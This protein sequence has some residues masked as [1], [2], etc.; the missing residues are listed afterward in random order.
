MKEVIRQLASYD[1]LQGIVEG[2]PIRIFWKDRDCN[3]L[4]C[5]TL[6][7]TDAGL[8][9]PDELIGKTDFD[10]GWKDQAE[11]YRA[12]DFSVM[13]SGKSR[14]RFEEPQTTPDGETA[15]LRTS[16]VPLRDKDKNIIGILGIYEDITEQKQVEQELKLAKAV[17][18]QAPLNITL[19]DSDARIHYINKTGCE[20]LGYTEEELLKMS[21]PDIDPLFPMEVWEQHW[22]E[23][24][25]NKS[26]PV[27]TEHRRKNGDIFPIEVMANYIEFGDQ[28]YNVAF[29]TDI[30]ERKQAEE[31]LKQSEAR[32]RDLFESSP[33][34]C[35]IID[36]NNL[37][38]LCNQAAADILGYESI[39][40]LQSTHPSK[41][42]PEIQPDGQKSFEKANEMMASAH[43][44]GV[45]RFEWIHLR[46]NGDC[47][48]V[49]VTLARIELAGKQQ[50]YC[51]WRDITE[52]K[53]VEEKLLSSEKR[54]D[55][56]MQGANDG[57][58]DWDL[59]TDEVYY[60]P[61]WF[62]MLGYDADA[63]PPVIDTWGELV[64][65]D[66]KDWILQR[67]TDYLEGRAGSFE[68][69]MRMCHK[70]G[71][72]VIVLSRASKV[73]R[74]SD[75]KP[76]RLVGTHVDITERKRVETKLLES[77]KRHREAQ[78]ISHLGNWSHNLLTNELEWSDEIFRIFG[79]DK[80]RFGASYEAFLDT[81]HPDDR[82]L[83]N[84]AYNDSVENRTRYSIEHRLLMKD[85]SIKWV[86]EHCA[87]TYAADGTPLI[88]SGTVLDITERKQQQ[89][90][91]EAS[92]KKF[93]T[94]FESSSDGLFILDMQGSFL[95]INRTAHE[96]LGYSKE[97]MLKM[98]L[99][100]LDPPEF[101]ARV[102]E[103]I[104]QILERGMATFESAHYRKDGSIMPVEINAR[105]I[106]LDGEKVLFSVIRDISDR[107][108][109]EDQ[110]RHSQKMEAIGTLVGGIAHDFN[111]MLAAMQG[112]IYMAKKQ[113]QDHPVTTDRLANIEQLSKRAADM[114]QQLLT[115]A[116]KDIV[117]M[118]LFSLN[119]FMEEGYKLIHAT[120]PENIDHQNIVC[121]ENLCIYGDTTQL[122]QAMMNLINNAVDAVADVPHPV[123]R[124]ILTPFESDEAFRQRHP[125]LLK[126]RFAC[127]TVK[128]NG[129][130]IPDEQLDKIFEPFFTTKDVGKGSG[131][132]LAML[133]GAIQT[134]GG[135][136]E[137]E[138]EA[139]SGTSF[140]VYFPLSDH[141]IETEIEEQMPGTEV[142]GETILLVDDE[143]D[144]RTTTSEVLTSMGYH[145]LEAVDGAEALD[146]FKSEMGRINII[147]T[148]VVMPRMSGTDLLN[149]VRLLDRKLPVILATG[150]DK[151]HLQGENI[152]DKSCRLINKPFDFDDLSR[153]IQLMLK[154][155]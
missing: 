111:N 106:E 122:Q 13:K 77:R 74:D 40:A 44:K 48:P 147:I 53:Q 140:R 72:D 14:L 80:S 149:S 17:M 142:H 105:I 33:D 88:S 133:Y 135:V 129:H 18:D 67:V 144:V 29:D 35:W 69:E 98:K 64:H 23:L 25:S 19:L 45:H 78:R 91:L 97:E 118:S 141:K 81:I 43:E 109:L 146:L 10:M 154:P 89:M 112:N 86:D 34:P 152:Q 76:V 125:A 54:F 136:I 134:H 21:I 108:M 30:T 128:D 38:T 57:L 20:T 49:E 71:H 119:A 15:W 116:R 8:S 36:E 28:A 82:E 41:L 6:F 126:E 117:E 85:G 26:V 92:R 150:Y 131:L 120:I 62:D 137:V 51:V 83:V 70:D 107:K 56:A 1:L 95:D 93:S 7:A 27:E 55:L 103:R 124:C 84:T 16:K 3:Y 155:E 42:S 2:I 121:K 151:S 143:Q 52:R 87:T 61:R 99:I 110:L 46:K 148:D 96:R 75:R 58:W 22:E 59:E 138:S 5:N 127:I 4:G 90:Q 68:V 79:I 94:L 123:I 32:F 100:E 50:L 65:P 66:D 37:F 60:S 12:D 104:G 24:K 114:V 102:P 130:G 73:L 139:G 11:L 145:V 101:A 31:A 132:G 63:L 39:K 115:F 47:F 113:M 9:H 153:S